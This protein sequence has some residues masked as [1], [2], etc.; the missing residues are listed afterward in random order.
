M[1]SID[2]IDSAI[3][4]LEDKV[5]KILLDDKMALNKKDN[6]MLPLLREKKVLMQTKNDLQYLIDNPIKE[7]QHCGISKYRND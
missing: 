4:E 6:L 7:N 2:F 5:N 3:K 1:R